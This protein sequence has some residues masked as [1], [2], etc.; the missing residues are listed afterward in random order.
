MKRFAISIL[1][2]VIFCS[3]LYSQDKDTLNK[4][5]SVRDSLKIPFN[6]NKILKKQSLSSF[7]DTTGIDFHI[8]ND[9]RNLAELL[10]EKSGY[11][12][13]TFSTGGRSL[14]SYNGS[15]SVGIFRN[16][17]QIN[18]L[19]T[20]TF[21][22]ENLSINEIDEVE[23]V[24]TPLSFMYGL[25]TQ[26]K[27]INILDKDNFQPNLF[28][29]FR[30]SQDRDGA[31]YADVYM[32]FPVSR[33][34][35]FILGINNHGTEGHYQNSDF[36]LWRGRFLF[37]YYPTDRINFKLSYY[38]NKLQRGLTEGL[39]SSTKDTLMN[40]NLAVPN[41]TDSY[42]KVYNQYSDFK[43]TGKFL[44]DSLSLTNIT[45]FT[46][47]SLRVYRDEENRATK[48]GIFIGKDFHS[49]QYGFDINQ[50]MNIV[51]FKLSQIKLIAGVKGLYN[52]YNYD[53]TTLYK[54][55]SILGQRYFDFNS[56]DIYSRL[57][58]MLKDVLISGAIKS[59]RFNNS[60]N[61]MYGA[62]I[63]YN[64]NFDKEAKLVLK[65]GTNN[66]TVGFDFESLFY[67]EYFYRYENNYN[68]SRQ[69][70]F[71]GGFNL[72]YK[73]V[74]FSFLNYHNSL[75]NNYSILNANYSAGLN[76]ENFQFNLNVNTINR[77][78]LTEEVT[79]AYVHSDTARL[80]PSVYGTLDICYKD[81]LFKNKLKLRT[82]FLVKYISNKPEVNYNQLSNTMV[83]NS[84]NAD[85]DNFDLDLYLGARIGKANINITIANILNSLFYNTSIYP[86]DD[87]NGLLR[88]I[89]RFTITWDFLN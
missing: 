27:L 50:S 84:N 6:H 55:D 40:I 54:L 19:F 52:L 83:N 43:I 46:Q 34:F 85:F 48:N 9:R 56:V 80:Y 24:S 70:Y 86:F 26:G 76:L 15:S 45:V 39:I 35:N 41:N 60:Y 30:Y 25:N 10:N 78:N 68:S 75:F 29:Q 77:N 63:K 20:G 17:M 64:I 44:K 31:L 82:G 38:I 5:I 37:N 74:Y 88:T 18:D 58:L 36:A 13:H 81:V 62:D 73:N 49:I 53:K 1:L 69:Q 22:V 28:T 12:V 23:E 65:G 3:N 32:N 67:N 4:I 89:S 42:E 16:G 59:Q 14:I 57:D 8:W 71:E 66:T 72:S 61:F 21:D 2:L 7:S 87:R 11:F 79:L 33:K 47:N 51:P